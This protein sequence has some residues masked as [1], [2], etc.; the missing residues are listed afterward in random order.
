MSDKIG[1][2]TIVPDDY[3]PKCNKKLD[4]A[5]CTDPKAFRGPSEGDISICAGCCTILRF[6]SDLKVREVTDDEMNALKQKHP[7][8]YQH[9]ER[10]RKITELMRL[11]RLFEESLCA[12]S[13]KKKPNS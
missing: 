1:K 3:C 2:T 6:G 11:D 7:D 10:I 13:Q 4:A 12:K 5:T 8:V 9:L